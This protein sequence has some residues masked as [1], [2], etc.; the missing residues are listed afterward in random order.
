MMAVLRYGTGTAAVGCRRGVSVI[1]RTGEVAVDEAV[2][3]TM[4]MA[5][6]RLAA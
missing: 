6:R 1:W 5:C 4:V 3:H 2:R